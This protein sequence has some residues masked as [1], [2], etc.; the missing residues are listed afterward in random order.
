MRLRTITNRYNRFP[1]SAQELAGPDLIVATKTDP[2]DPWG[3]ESLAHVK[4]EC[5]PLGGK[6]VG[7][8]QLFSCPPAA[9]VFSK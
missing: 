1:L 2:T 9:L 7:T 5:Q 4:A 3:V 6:S 8:Y